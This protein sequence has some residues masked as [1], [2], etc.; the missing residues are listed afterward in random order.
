MSDAEDLIP[1]VNSH[2]DADE[3]NALA[4][5]ALCSGI[6]DR[7][8]PGAHFSVYPMS[9]A[10]ADPILAVNP[11]RGP[12][13]LGHD[14]KLRQGDGEDLIAFTVRVLAEMA[15]EA[16]ALASDYHADSARLDRLADYMN[17]PGPWSGGAK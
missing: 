17:R 7:E 15:E 3:L 12:I 16:N 9:L 1:I 6:V 5:D 13:L 10:G 4:D 2:S 8:R 11:G 14:L